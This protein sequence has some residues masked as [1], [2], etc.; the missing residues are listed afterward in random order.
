MRR[1]LVLALVTVVL[2]VVVLAG[3]AHTAVQ[4]YVMA[5]FEGVGSDGRLTLLFMGSDSG[6]PRPGSP[7]SGRS[8]GLHIVSLSVDRTRVSIVSFPRDS[9]VAVA[10]QG[11]NKINACLA[12]GP[13]A[14]VATVQSLSGIEFDGYMLTSF[15]GFVRGVNAIGGVTVDVE[16]R[17]NDPGGAHSDL[18]AG[19]QTLN[20]DQAL[21]YVRDRH[22]RPGGDLDRAES[23]AK[24]LKSAHAM[25]VGQQPSLF[26]IHQLV[27]ILHATTVSTLSGADQLRLAA[28]G[29]RIPSENVV[30]QRLG[31]TL[32]TVGSASVVFLTDAADATLADLRADG[33]L[34]GVS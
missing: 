8:D 21:S 31:A 22:S 9:W 16:Q 27:A 4:A 24:F 7:L 34:D 2:D 20:G 29:L 33:I 28:T 13:D 32:G 18:Q 6:P 14:C 11:T 19:V 12:T 1:R 25:L 15:Q 17:L 30:Y 23:H 26:R 3:A 5:P 10:G